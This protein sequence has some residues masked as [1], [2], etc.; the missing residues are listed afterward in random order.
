MQNLDQKRLQHTPG[1]DSW[2]NEE[3]S[4]SYCLYASC[5]KFIATVTDNPSHTK[6]QIS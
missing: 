5:S 1:S 4:I 6:Q 2:D 3:A